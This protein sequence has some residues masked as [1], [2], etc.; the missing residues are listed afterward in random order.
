MS[1][2]CNVRDDGRPGPCGLFLDEH[3]LRDGVWVHPD[4]PPAD[5]E[6]EAYCHRT[7]NACSGR[8]CWVC[9]PNFFEETK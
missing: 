1:A 7:D 4:E 5:P 3:R 6:G 2:G 9:Q 8:A